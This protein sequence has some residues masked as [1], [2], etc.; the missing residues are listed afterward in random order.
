MSGHRVTQN[1]ATHFY[2]STKCAVR[3]ITEATRMEL[4]EAKT[5]IRVS[6]SGRHIMPSMVLYLDVIIMIFIG[7]N[8]LN[9]L[10]AILCKIEA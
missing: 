8:V 10:F 7:P 1:P 5:N 9:V 2:A 4:R 3:A 6:V